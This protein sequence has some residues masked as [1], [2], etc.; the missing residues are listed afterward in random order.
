[1]DRTSR[2]CRSIIVC[3]ALLAFMNANRNTGED[4]VKNNVAHSVSKSYT[5][6]EEIVELNKITTTDEDFERLAER[7]NERIK[8]DR[9]SES[10]QSSASLVSS[11]EIY[12]DSND[13]A[14]KKNFGSKNIETGPVYLQDRLLM[15]YVSDEQ[16]VGAVLASL[17]G[18]KIEIAEQSEMAE[19]FRN[20]N[21][22]VEEKGLEDLFKKNEDKVEISWSSLL[23]E[24]TDK[25]YLMNIHDFEEYLAELEQGRV[26]SEEELADK[27][28]E[29]ILLTLN[30]EL[31]NPYEFYTADGYRIALDSLGGIEDLEIEHSEFGSTNKKDKNT[32]V[33]KAKDSKTDWIIIAKLN[34][35]MKIYDV[36]LL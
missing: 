2:I 18:D 8:R 25:D 16:R 28:N 21:E 22:A 20:R 23:R 27:F 31:G 12:A 3:C 7:C 29:C 13:R 33:V 14:S 11:S 35:D 24:G 30:E 10:K 17:I 4:T 36:D 34:A 6:S 32:L 1:M 19:A 15:R 9:V 5:S 26:V